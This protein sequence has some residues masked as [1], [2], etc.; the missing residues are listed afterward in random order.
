MSS[1]SLAVVPRA[2]PD[3]VRIAA[4]SAALALNLAA[5]VAALR[6]KAPLLPST[7]VPPASMTVDWIESPPPVP[8]PPPPVVK[9][10]PKPV[11]VPRAAP[12]PVAPPVVAPVSEPDAAA[13]PA[14]VAPPATPAP[15]TDA[16]APVEASLAY[17]SAPLRYPGMALRQRMQGTVLLRVLVDETGRP[18]EVQVAHSS[19]Y[20]LLDRSARE[21]VLS[22]WRFDPAM[23]GGHAVKAWAQV[24]VS[25]ALRQL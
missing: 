9:P 25:F 8:P 2:H 5:F 14:P 20:P 11:P 6:P 15:A 24:P 22:G 16:T 12:V 10:L 19:G 18:V 23:V 7:L 4:L 3:P 13:T 1:A 21:Q 17:R